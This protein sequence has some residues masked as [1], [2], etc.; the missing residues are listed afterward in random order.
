MLQTSEIRQSKSTGL[1]SDPRI[2]AVGLKKRLI[3]LRNSPTF[4]FRNLLAGGT[5]LNFLQYFS[6]T[7]TY[8]DDSKSLSPDF[9]DTILTFEP[10]YTP[11]Y[12]FL[13]T[14]TTFHAARPEK[15]IELMKRGL[16]QIEP[17]TVADGFYIWRYKGIDELLFLGDGKA[18][19]HSFETA[20]DW[21]AQSDYADSDV[22]EKASRQTAEF[23]AQN[24]ESEIAQMKA[25]SSL[26]ASA[27]NQTTRQQAIDQIEKLGGKVTITENGQF[28][29]EFPT[30]KSR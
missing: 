8:P 15:T 25:W 10:F 14:S 2:N 16:E 27:L 22:I 29:V 30:D 20:A 6:D 19:Q 5:F 12:L 3:V 13:S 26:L 9:F 7:L 11:Y 28:K 1:Q 21:A 4:G 23:L 24:P 18:A 17:T